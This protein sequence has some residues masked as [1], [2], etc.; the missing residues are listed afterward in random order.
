MYKNHNLKSPHFTIQKL[1]DGVFAVLHKEGG[2]AIGNAG[3]VDLGDST[4][5]F[6]TFISHLAARD[7]RL[8][9]G[10]LTGNP[11]KYVVNSHYHNDHVRG[12]QVFQQA[13]IIATRGTLELL[14]SA[15]Q[16]ELTWDQ[17]APDKYEEYSI[18]YEAAEDDE[19]RDRLKF[20]LDYYRVIAESLPDLEMRYPARW[21]LDKLQLEGSGRSVEL[22]SYG[23][24]HTGSDTFMLLPEEKIAFLGDL[25]FVE[26]Q[27]YLVDGDPAA[28]LETLIKIKGL[29]AEV[30]VPGHGPVGSV[31]DIDLEADYIHTLQ[32]LVKRVSANGEQ[33][34]EDMLPT[35]FKDWEF[36]MFFLPNV[37][38]LENWLSNNK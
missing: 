1:C 19:T 25:L 28:W 20:W 2:G 4:L 35:K 8:A 29:G 10:E 7:L 14:E 31:N 15:G 23:A 6:D 5:V 33:I 38:F 9:A 18:K 34:N 11:V 17:A 32:E 16:E 24:G 30:F 3:I 37:E 36:P 27:P 12:N 13:E 26:S 21:F 22:I